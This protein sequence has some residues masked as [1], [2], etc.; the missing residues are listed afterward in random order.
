MLC[1]TEQASEANF[2]ENFALLEDKTVLRIQN[3]TT[4]GSVPETS[5][6]TII[7]KRKSSATSNS[8]DS[9][10][11]TLADSNVQTSNPHEPF[12]SKNLEFSSDTTK[13][14]I[15]I[16]TK[17]WNRSAPYETSSSATQGGCDFSSRKG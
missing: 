3:R 6:L 4:N 17:N 14:K 8:L 15:K 12:L 7:H 9:V 1:S 2:Q 11:P 13:Q 5:P 16:K 10:Y